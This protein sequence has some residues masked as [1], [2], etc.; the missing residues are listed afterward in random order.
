MR[1][2]SALIVVAAF[3]ASATLV[4]AQ[5]PTEITINDAGV[6]PENVTSSQD[7]AVYF[8]STA[9]GT[10]YRAAPGA[11]QAEPWIQASAAGLSNVLGVLAD[12]KSNTLW[13]CQNS[14]GGRG[15]A[16][17]TGQTALRSFDLKTGAAKGIY[18]FPSNGG[19]CNDMAIAPDGTVYATETLS[20][21]IHRLKPGAAALDLW[22]PADPRLAGVDGIAMLGDGAVYVNAFFSGDIFRIPVNADGSAGLMVKIETSMPLSRPDGL[23][24]VGPRTL[25]QAEG[26]GRVTELTID[27]NRAEVRVVKDGLPGASGV[28]LVGETALVLV[29]RAKAVVVPYRRP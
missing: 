24:A 4:R 15:G 12:D 6:Q 5:A 20:N 27:G 18:P 16:P 29:E 13:V 14:T 22:V 1:V 25:I 8:G 21:R 19:I 26:Q 2:A 23:R 3:V 10:I 17:V 7:G 28:T 9:K 11:S